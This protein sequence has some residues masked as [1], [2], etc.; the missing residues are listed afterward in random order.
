[1]NVP[2]NCDHCGKRR[3]PGSFR[4]CPQCLDERSAV[5][6]KQDM[7]EYPSMMEDVAIRRPLDHIPG[8]QIDSEVIAKIQERLMA[9]EDELATLRE[10]AETKR[11][12]PDVEERLALLEAVAAAG[13]LAESPSAVGKAHT[14]EHKGHYFQCFDDGSV[15][16]DTANGSLLTIGP[17]GFTRVVRPTNA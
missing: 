12:L 5:R 3:A 13:R 15:R 11:V 6:P 16:I 10:R 14:L 7:A 2:L 8:V 4:L 1:M 9:V 17:D